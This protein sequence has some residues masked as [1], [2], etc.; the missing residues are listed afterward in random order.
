[1]QIQNKIVRF[2]I[3]KHDQISQHQ[4]RKHQRPP[5]GNRFVRIRFSAQPFG[6]EQFAP[7]GRHRVQQ[8]RVLNPVA[9]QLTEQHILPRLVKGGKSRHR[10]K[11]FA[12]KSRL[13]YGKEPRIVKVKKKMYFFVDLRFEAGYKFVCLK[14]LT[15]SG[16]NGRMVMQRTANP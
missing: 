6:N 5:D 14:G 1:M 9:D 10:K 7:N 12:I 2:D 16:P 4:R 15:A 8:S 3:G 13:N 11:P